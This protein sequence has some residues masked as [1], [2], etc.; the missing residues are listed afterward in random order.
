LKRRDFIQDS[1]AAASA[2][3][4]GGALPAGAAPQAGRGRLFPPQSAQETPP[5]AADQLPDLAP[6]RWIWYPS[7]RCLQNTFVLF[8][9]RLDLA[10][11]CIRATGWISADSRYLL[12]VNGR[13]IQWGPAPCDPRWLEADPVDL[14]AA[15]A[16]GPN[17]IG[18]QVLFYG[19]G[20]G[21]SPL[22]KPGFLFHLQIECS[23]GSKQTIVSD[24][25][26]HAHLARA[27]PPGQYKRW[28]LRALQEV[29][30]A[31]LYPY[32]W[33]TTTLP[34]DDPGFA[35]WFPAMP[36]DCP[37]NKPPLC[38]TYPD[39]LF[40]TSGVSASCALRPRRIPPMKETL[41][42]SRLTE[43]MW[44]KWLRAPE[45]YFECRPPNAFETIR[46]SAAQEIAEGQWR[47]ELDGARA[48][49]LTFELNEQMAGWPFFTID[50][51]AGTTLEL[52]VQEGHTAGGPVL[53]DTHFDS[54]S[55]F[56]CREGRNRFE[57]FDYECCRWIQLHIRGAKG[58]V[59]VSNVGMR[60]RVFPWPQQPNIRF[61]EPALD[62]LIAAS[63]NTL[64]NSAI[65]T[66]MDGAGRERQQYSGDGGHQ[67]HAVQLT[68]GESRLPARYLTTYSQGL[69]KDGF[70]LDCWPA[71]DRLARLMERQLDL[72]PWGPLLDHGVGFNFDNY[73]H[74][75]Y[76]GQL[77]DLRE[78]YP[79]LLR[80]ARYLEGIVAPDGLLPVE[81]LGI[82]AVW[83]DHIAYQRQR[84]KQCAFNLYAAAM[85]QYA[86]APICRAFGDRASEEAATK[87]GQRIQAAAVR[88]FWSPARETFIN[89]LPWLE[90]EH[91]PRM[92]DRSLA[93]AILFDQCPGGRSANL[94]RALAECPPEMGFSYPCNAGWR[95]WALAQGGRAD[96]VVKDFRERWATLD[97]VRLNNTLQEDW[98]AQ[99]DSSSEWSHC[100]VAPLYVTHMSL[101]GIRPLEPGFRR[102][103]IHPRPAD[104]ELLEVTTHT[105][106][107]PLLFASRGKPGARD[108]TLNLP[109]GCAGELVVRA[110]ENLSLPKLASPAP[111]GHLR[112][113]LPAGE[114]KLHLTAT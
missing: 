27:W 26:W 57:T 23:D 107:G 101:A 5:L 12:E 50:A 68:L 40:D 96:V 66:L 54:W 39:Y 58:T 73:Y 35:N 69:T 70:F 93:T 46:Q 75:L 10:A 100:P 51:P 9:R 106:L 94:I 25:T 33:T 77:D 11:P 48:A 78:P 49:A 3:T 17:V 32:G 74:Y 53:L 29:F 30:D 108:I 91:Q 114:T 90:E 87:M 65:E 31:R 13:R 67:M 2:F 63:V 15:L 84:H 44:I 104:L 92:C 64:N 36:L 20:D 72:T 1:A 59:T 83:M 99:P 52:M 80:F 97:S 8:R 62:R 42:R 43:S 19:Q 61:G 47:V 98:V 105:P 4:L 22:G 110:E 37:P 41:E 111:S 82:P 45:E 102:C 109:A 89:N 16:A 81:N 86:L 71:Y 21:T 85:L 28:Y 88:R 79:R 6:A 7:G 24:S 76:S 14:S 55:R 34:P 113:R 38:S 112:H 60:R 56:I 95:L 103:E 18:A